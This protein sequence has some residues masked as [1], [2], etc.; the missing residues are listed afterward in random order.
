[1]KNILTFT[2]FVLLL[3]CTPIVKKS[4][5]ETIQIAQPN[6]T[7]YNN[8]EMVDKKHDRLLKIAKELILKGERKEAIVNYLNPI[9]VDYEKIYLNSSKRIYNARTKEEYS[10]YSMSAIN[11][12][13]EPHIL[14]TNW[15]MAYF[16]KGYTLLELKELKLAEKSIRQA[17][18]LS[19]SNSKYLSE[20][21]HLL[22]IKRDWRG[23]LN[24]YRLAEKSATLFSPQNLKQKELLT[25]K[26]GIGFSYT[27]LKELNNAESTYKEILEIDSKDRVAIK[28]LKYIKGLRR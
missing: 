26:R 16:L 8:Y 28:E 12:G 18:Y 15:S 20:L 17:L 2:T 25:A 22:H 9:I 23:A 13:R 4:S 6:S 11:D 5:N 19:P 3:G 24:S 27:E 21:G 10:F 14:S 7:I 1:M